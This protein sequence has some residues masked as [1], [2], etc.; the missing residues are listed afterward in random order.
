[1]IC[2][3]QIQLQEVNKADE[4]L[5]EFLDCFEKLYGKE[6]C[7]M[8]LHLHAHLKACILDYGPVYSFWLFSFERM[9]GVL[10]SFRTNSHDISVQLMRRF[11]SI[12]AYAIRNWPEEYRDNFSKLIDKC[13]YDKGSL[14]QGSLNDLLTFPYAV[15]IQSLPPV[16]EHA[17]E[18]H[19]KS[20]VH[21][22]I[23]E[24]AQSSTFDVLALYEKC[25]AIKIG[26]FVIG[27]SSSRFYTVSV[28][29]VQAF[30]EEKLA[31]IQYYVKCAVRIEGKT[32]YIWLV[33]LSFFPEHQCK[34]WYGHPTEVWGGIP[35]IDIYF[36]PLHSILN[37]VTF[38]KCN[39]NFGRIIGTDSVIVVTPLC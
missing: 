27:S 25:G 36:L 11:L 31:E 7:T 24:V 19:V 30:G 22:A 1:M 29:K 10:G 9:N 23:E 33:A 18:P 32:L 39:V 3:R 12:Q 16:H 5:M 21:N 6:F 38:T 4:L 2:R 28:V 34:V 17:F 14:S 15:Q 35:D 13:E 26:R 8:N 20:D 37:R